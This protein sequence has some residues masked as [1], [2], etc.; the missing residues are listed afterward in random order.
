MDLLQLRY[1][2]TVAQLEHM[3]RAAEKIGIAQPSLS[4]MIGRLEKELGVPLFD[5]RGRQIQL[6]Q[7]G[8]VF[9]RQVERAFFELDEGK[10]QLQDMAGLEHGQIAISSVNVALLAEVLSSFYIQH[11]CINFRLYQHSNQAMIKQLELGDIDLCLASPPIVAPNIGWISLMTEEIFLIVPK[12]HPLAARKSIRLREVAGEP[13][14]SLKSGYGLRDIT[15]QYCQQA[16]FMPRIVFEGNEPIAIRGLV[17]AGLGLAFASA[18]SWNHLVVQPDASICIL[19]IEEPICQRTIGL[20]WL[21][22]RYHSQ[23][24]RQFT[25]F[26]LDYFA[27]YTTPPIIQNE[28]QFL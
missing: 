13:F 2:Q 1:F 10:R 18:A 5:R 4:K 3:T 8:K 12:Q 16:G 6:N 21:E 22:G 28:N 27:S 25:H 9:L 19:R 17:K 15:D 11:P 24:V 7:F 23:A 20:G 26:I 14:V